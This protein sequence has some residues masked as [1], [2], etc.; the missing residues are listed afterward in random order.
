V[1]APRAGADPGAGMA[2]P[3]PAYY[4]GL[5]APAVPAQQIARI[6]Y[7]GFDT[8]YAEFMRLTRSARAYFD[9]GDWLR[10]QQQQK[11]RTDLYQRYVGRTLRSLSAVT[12]L[13]PRDLELWKQAH[14]AYAEQVAGRVDVEVAET[15]FNAITRKIFNTVGVNPEIEFL[16]ADSGRHAPVQPG[17]VRRLPW[18]DDPKAVLRAVLRHPRPALRF[19]D[20]EGDVEYLEQRMR[21]ACPLWADGGQP[22]AVEVVKTLF[23]RPKEGYVVARVLRGDAVSPLVVP[24]Q[25]WHDGMVVDGA[26]LSEA[27]LMPVFSSTRSYL[28][29]DVRQPS[30]L[31]DLLGSLMPQLSRSELYI[32]VAHH[33]H[34][35]SLIFRELVDYLQGSDDRLVIAPG[36]RGLV[37]TVFTMPSYRNV[38]KMIRDEPDKP[39]I[40]RAGVL[41][42]YRDVF[43][44]QRVGRLA[45]TQEFEFLAFDR[46]RFDPA[47]LEE[48]RALADSQVTIRGDRVIIGHAYIEEKMT[49][50]DLYLAEASDEQAI[51]ALHDFGMAIREL[52]A[53][54][55]FPGD[56]LWKNFGVTRFGRLVL[57]DY[58]EIRPLLDCNFRHI[59]PPRSWEEEM[60]ATPYYTVRDNDVFPEEWVPFVAPRRPPAWRDAFMAAHGEL[61]DAE[62]W[63]GVQEDLVA[64]RLRV[65]LPYASRRA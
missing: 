49:P 19:R 8:F 47:C 22:D 11:S 9:A 43:R 45:D 63:R 4:A 50:L 46:A 10:L 40:V 55:I 59:P 28:F 61:F 15:F 30:V 29:V 7:D 1:S 25:S 51:G 41:E 21:A 16:D 36:I 6:I 14:V 58:D 34:G 53:H 20:L 32:A 3:G 57:Y 13:Y 38:F 31:V 24:V 44:G 17:L 27:E 48:L 26:L 42:S 35:K 54:N 2:T 23:F 62:W 60:S 5:A 52:A 12:R 65:N 33:R 18:G 39:G 64:G 56:L 37:M